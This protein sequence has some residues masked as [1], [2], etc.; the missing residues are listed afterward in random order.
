MSRKGIVLLTVAAVVAGSLC[1]FCLLPPEGLIV[2]K[3]YIL[4]I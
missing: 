4:Y 3:L 2:T 1:G